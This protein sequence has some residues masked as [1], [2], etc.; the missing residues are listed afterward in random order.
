M[1]RFKPMV[2]LRSLPILLAGMMLPVAA[3]AAEDMVKMTSEHDVAETEERLLSALQEKGFTVM[4]QVDHAAGARSVDL[5]LEPT[6]LVIFGNPAGGTRLM[7]C[8][9]SMAIDLPMKMLIWRDGDEVRIAYNSAEYLAERHDL[10]DC[11]A[12]V[13]E[14]MGQVLDGLA[15]RAAG[16]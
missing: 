7:Q 16:R 9:R 6:R 11:A 2:M 12:P 4:A 1:N 14:K 3:S 8:R 5:E 15:R 13:Q 10:G